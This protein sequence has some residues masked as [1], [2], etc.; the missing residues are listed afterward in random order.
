MGTN[1][2]VPQS[3]PWT[4]T[5]KDIRRTDGEFYVYVGGEFVGCRRTYFEAEELAN[6]T[7]YAIL[8]ATTPVTE[9]EAA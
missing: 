6:E 1:A 5:T 3:E 4:A 8:L 9:S 2:I 7:A